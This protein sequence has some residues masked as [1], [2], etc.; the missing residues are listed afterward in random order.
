MKHVKLFENFNSLEN[1]PL[2][3]RLS[4]MEN[5]LKSDVDEFL[6]G[7]ENNPENIGVNALDALNNAWR[8]FIIESSDKMGVY[9]RSDDEDAD[10]G[11]KVIDPEMDMAIKDRIKSGNNPFEIV[12]RVTKTLELFYNLG[13]KI[14]GGSSYEEMVRMAMDKNPSK[15]H[16]IYIPD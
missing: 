8:N 3:D 5:T 9:A 4:N 14:N 16:M 12:Q 15:A 1:L 11:F 7:W 10:D 2:E 13:L 6:K